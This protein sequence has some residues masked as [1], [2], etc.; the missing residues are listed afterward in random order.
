MHCKCV[1]FLQRENKSESSSFTGNFVVPQLTMC[2][3]LTGK[4]VISTICF[5]ARPN[6]NQLVSDPYLRIPQISR[7]CAHN[8]LNYSVNRKTRQNSTPGR[9]GKGNNKNITLITITI[10]TQASGS[11]LVEFL[12]LCI[13][14]KIQV[15]SWKHSAN[16]KS[17]CS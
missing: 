17:T 7:K 9:S 3:W 16:N 2:W 4:H 11:E 10:K 1:T 5:V 14:T 12:V 13:F 8:F 6:F 15:N